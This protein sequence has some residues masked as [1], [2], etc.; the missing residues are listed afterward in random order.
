MLSFFS[1]LHNAVNYTTI[2]FVA[3][4]GCLQ[5]TRFFRSCNSI[6]ST[7]EWQTI[8]EGAGV[9]TDAS[10]AAMPVWH[11]YVAGT[12]PTNGQSKFTAK[13]EIKDGDDVAMP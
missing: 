4:S 9:K 8:S 3:A 5:S 13:I 6:A 12:A 1:F 10:G 11:D 2:L 7:S